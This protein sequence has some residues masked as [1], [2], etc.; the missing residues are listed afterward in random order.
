M[1]SAYGL[2]DLIEKVG[3]QESLVLKNLDL[4]GQDM[5]VLPV[6][7]SQHPHDVD[8]IGA[9]RTLPMRKMPSIS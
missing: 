2:S 1:R 3:S 6:V 5:E 7:M 8:P 4:R 9:D